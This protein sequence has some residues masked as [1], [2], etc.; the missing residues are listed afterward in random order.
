MYMEIYLL[1]K[2]LEVRNVSQLI[3]IVSV[4]QS[5]CFL[6]YVLGNFFLVISR[7]II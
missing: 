2:Y 5:Y 4:H 3:I 6:F 7:L 1:H